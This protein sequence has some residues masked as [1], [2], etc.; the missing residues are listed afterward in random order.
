MYWQDQEEENIYQ[1]T[2]D[3]GYYFPDTLAT[4]IYEK[5]L[6]YN[7]FME[8]TVDIDKQIFEIYSYSERVLQNNINTTKNSRELLIYDNN[9]RL[10]TGDTI[11][12]SGCTNIGN[13][14]GLNKEY[15]VT[16]LS[17]NNYTIRS[18]PQKIK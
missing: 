13:L 8:V 7:V 10:K 16:V 17:S 5:A 4:E 11:I 3:D 6:E 2:I 14:S 1:I 12:M 15:T 18:R 9:H